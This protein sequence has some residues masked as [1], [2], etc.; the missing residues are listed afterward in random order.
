[1]ANKPM[2]KFFFKSN[3][4]KIPANLGKR[5][6]TMPIA[7]SKQCHRILFV[8]NTSCWV[9]CTLQMIVWDK[10]KGLKESHSGIEERH[11]VWVN[12]KEI[13]NIWLILCTHLLW[14]ICDIQIFFNIW[15]QN[16]NVW[17][18]LR[19]KWCHFVF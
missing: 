15:K 2:H 3:L 11:L 4:R 1:M 5:E 13:A 7:K 18:Y 16:Q 19:F 9:W 10:I 12:I 17:R 8:V 6:L 14:R